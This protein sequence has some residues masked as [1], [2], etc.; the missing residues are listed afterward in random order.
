MQTLIIKD[1][2]KEKVVSTQYNTDKEARVAMANS[3]INPGYV[4]EMENKLESNICIADF[5]EKILKQLSYEINNSDEMGINEIRD[6]LQKQI[7]NAERLTN[8]EKNQ[9]SMLV[10]ILYPR[11]YRY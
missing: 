8:A 2:N 10:D 1:S 5:L 4:F 9:I 7:E 3:E 6:Y 11:Q